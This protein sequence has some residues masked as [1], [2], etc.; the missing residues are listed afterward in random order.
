MLSLDIKNK[1]TWLIAGLV[2]LFAVFALIIRLIP[3]F[4]LGNSD[5][6]MV[7]AMDDPLYNLRQTEQI[8]MNFPNYAWFDPM[9]H[10]PTGSMIY[11]GSLFPT[12]ASILCI[13]TGATTQSAIITTCLMVPP[14]MAAAI[15][16]IM[17]FVGKACGDYKTGILASGLTAVVTGQYF[18][19]SF[20]G[21]FDHHIAEVLFSTIF[22]LFYM[23]AVVS[24][25]DTKINLREIATY[26]RTGLFAA[27]A[28]ITYILGLLVM[29]TMILFAMIAGIFTVIQFVIDFY[30]GRTSEYL[31]VINTVIFVLAIAGLLAF[32][33]KNPG[34]DL[35][36]YSIGHVYAY[37]GMI[38]GTWV[39]Y[40]LA[41]FLRDKEKYTY[42]A[43]IAGCGLLFALLL[44][45][46][47]PQLFNLLIYDF[48]SFFGRAPVTETV[49]EARGWE[50][51]MAW[52]VF[53]Y[54]LI[55]MVG[56]ILVM[57]YNNIR[58]EHPHQVFAIIW[59]VLMF[60]STCQHV[61]YEYYLAVNLAL[62]SA[63][64]ISF[65]FD[66]GS[67]DLY[68]L[69]SGVSEGKRDVIEEE[70]SPRGKKQKRAHKKASSSSSMGYVA[71]GCI[72]LTAG[73]G[74]F[75]V[76]TSVSYNINV[77][78]SDPLRMNADWKETAEWM[79]NNTPSPGIDYNKI[80]DKAT[81]LYPPQ[82]YGVM[83]W[84]DYG[85]V[86]TY[87]G[88]RIPNA[89][90]FQQNVAGDTGAAAYFMSDTEDMANHILDVQKTRY[91]VTD[92]EM[93]TGKF[94]AM[95]TWYNAT[96]A[97]SPYQKVMY[98][99]SPSNPNSLQPVTLNGQKYFMTTVSRLHN[100]DG[101]KTEPSIVYYFEYT[102]PSI[103]HIQ[104]PLITNAIQTNVTDARVKA[105]QFNQ[106]AQGGYHTVVLTPEILH[107]IDTIPALRHYRLV[108]ESPTNA[109]NSPTADIRYV[110][111]FE[112]VKGAHIR[113][114]GTIE[115]PIVTNT[116]RT[117]IYRQDSIDGEFIVPYATTGN[118]Y[119]VK[120]S[121]KYRII[122][123]GQQY[124]VPESAVEQGLTIQ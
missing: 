13:L 51:A 14:L 46:A 121:G 84:W 38:G 71:V 72:I 112:Y 27:L 91:V 19:R 100:F 26:K 52:Q 67:K 110:K 23:Y 107:P 62:L 83:S 86:I 15:V 122:G 55:L 115:V 24:E 34:I 114:S 80:Y 53:N 63:V 48:F 17:Y 75:F 89:N 6:L 58:D 96:L 120:A 32:G 60:I 87:I 116:G 99:R 43:A 73:M 39:L 30:R 40:G 18:M 119:E 104:F 102:D 1:R 94:W 85:H 42:I 31:L 4:N 35:S 106:R 36:T 45:I 44:Y 124:D 105:E 10:Y 22:C 9:T 90:P 103:T 88:K 25:K 28:G 68:R 111:V 123:T 66:W 113:G 20:F 8:L 97:T 56:G 98:T 109:L 12:I 47:S 11:W 3:F 41:R 59:S 74:A 49:Q 93:D 7:V 101:S 21:Y 77:A 5:P 50:P 57:I 65:A 29:P 82:A 54:G 78:S 79:A 118:P 76:Y 95:S 108:H 33:I 117:F 64:Y 37:I 61:R 69:I 92:I 70:G 81:F 16:V 2:I